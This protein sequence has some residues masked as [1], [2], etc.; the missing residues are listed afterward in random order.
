M[1]RLRTAAAAAAASSSSDISSSDDGDDEGDV[2]MMEVDWKRLAVP[3][4]RAELKKRGL[5][6]K[7]LKAELA[8]PRNFD[9]CSFLL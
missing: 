4:L 6:H 9:F 2:L 3:K 7:G 8:Q 1:T 5:D